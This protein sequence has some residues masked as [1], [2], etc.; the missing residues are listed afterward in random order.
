MKGSNYTCS[1]YICI[2]GDDFDGHDFVRIAERYG[3]VAIV[4]ERVL[5]T[6]LTQIIVEDSRSAMSLIAG[7]F[8]NRPADKLRI[9]GVTGTNGKTTTAHLIKRIMDKAGIKCGVIGTLGTFYDNK[10]IEPSKSHFILVKTIPLIFCSL[11]IL[12]LII[13]LGILLSLSLYTI[14]GYAFPFGAMS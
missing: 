11:V 8:Y 10:E 1:L 4:S 5:E 6:S 3:A 13:S 14:T 9:I 12:V 2:K 7:N